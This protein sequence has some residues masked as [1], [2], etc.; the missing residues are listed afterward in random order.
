LIDLSRSP[1][2]PYDHQ[3]EGVERLAQLVEPEIGRIYPGC[4]ALFDEPGA[5]KSKQIIDVAQVLFELGHIKNV[6]VVVPNQAKDVWFDRDIGEI[7][8]HAWPNLPMKISLFHSRMRSWSRGQRGVQPLHWLITNYEYI[9]VGRDKEF[10]NLGFLLMAAS[11][12]TLLVLDESSAVGSHRARQTKACFKLRQE[13]GRVVIM[14]GTPESTGIGST[15]NPEDGSVASLYSQAAIMD[16]RILNCKNWHHFCARHAVM[17]G[18]RNK[19]IIGWR[20]VEDIQKRLAPYVLRR[21]K[22]DCLDLPEKLPPSLINTPLSKESWKLYRQMRDD[23]V[24]WLSGQQVSFT[25]QAGVRVMRLAQITAGLLGGVTQQ[26]PCSPCG[27]TGVVGD[28]PCEDCG[29]AGSVFVGKPPAN[30]GREKLDVV[31]QWIK[32]LQA[33]NPKAKA[34]IWCRFRPEVE[35][36]AGEIRSLFPSTD[37]G[38]LWGG[39]KPSE[40]LGVLK[41]LKPGHA[42]EGPVIVVGTP[43]SGS[44]GLDFAAASYVYWASHGTSL[45]DRIQADDRVHRP[46][47]VNKVWYGELTATGPDGQ[48]TVDHSLVKALRRKENA[49]NWTC[50]AWVKELD[51]EY[52]NP[53]E[54][55]QSEEKA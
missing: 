15:E 16:P 43:S 19:Q 41:L 38:N 6:I 13:C 32:D 23:A 21:L 1:R 28:E 20:G 30:I 4:F 42:P 8:T 55:V 10:S 22:K 29:G 31:L 25:R 53:E 27:A 11:K 5:G 34:V 36:M 47:Q 18:W 37:V 12:N 3:R 2:K 45:K 35:R 7:V 40:R 48:K 44:V 49:A 51:S 14:N 24:A 54:G 50:A 9:R 33:E 52:E 17:G 39:Q 26:V 46:G